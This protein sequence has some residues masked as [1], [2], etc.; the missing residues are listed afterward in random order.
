MVPD[1]LLGNRF[2]PL[3]RLLALLR[4]NGGEENVV[5]EG[6]LNGL[7]QTC[8]KGRHPCVPL[9]LVFVI[10]GLEHVGRDHHFIAVRDR[11]TRLV[12]RQNDGTFAGQR[13]DRR[14]LRLALLGLDLFRRA[15]EGGLGSCDSE[16]M[17]IRQPV[18]RAAR[19]TFWPDLPMASD[20]M[21]S[22]TRTKQ[23]F[24]SSLT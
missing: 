2:V 11:L 24:F 16:R 19:R 7:L 8:G 4:G 14:P 3:R 13:L 6:V 23:D 9:L 10:K 17:S 5:M 21:L 18:S 1:R 22:G 12:R 20:S 15:G